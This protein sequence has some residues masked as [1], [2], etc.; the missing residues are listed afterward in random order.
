MRGPIGRVEWIKSF[1]LVVLLIRIILPLSMKVITSNKKFEKLLIR[2]IDKHEHISFAVAWASAKTQAYTALIEARGKISTTTIGIHFY[3]TDPDVLDRFIE[4]EQVRF[5]AQPG[6]VF[7]PKVYFFS[8][9]KGWDAII[10]SANMTMG[11]MKK[12]QEMG[13]HISHADD[14]DGSV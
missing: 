12:N 13:I 7:H 11:A 5:I 1:S 14:P 8:S 3:Q 2:L 10:G 9:T 4:S 6:G